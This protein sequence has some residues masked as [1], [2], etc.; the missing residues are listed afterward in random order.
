M[1]Q[2]YYYIKYVSKKDNKYFAAMITPAKCE[3]SA[4]FYINQKYQI[5]KDK[6]ELSRCE[7]ISYKIFSRLEKW[8]NLKIKKLE[9]ERKKNP[10]RINK[11]LNYLLWVSSVVGKDKIRNYYDDNYWKK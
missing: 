3:R 4:L 6:W 11:M 1:A 5:S 10:P 7:E 8:Q 2:K 9:E